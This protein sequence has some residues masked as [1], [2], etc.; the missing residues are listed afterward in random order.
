MRLIILRYARI[1]RIEAIGLLASAVGGVGSGRPAILATGSAGSSACFH[2]D[3]GK[4][5]VFEKFE[6]G[7]PGAGADG[8]VGWSW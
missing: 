7:V 2:E 5:A 4:L 8:Q 6:S 1:D 3:G